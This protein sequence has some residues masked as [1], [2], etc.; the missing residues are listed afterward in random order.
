MPHRKPAAKK[1]KM[2][3]FLFVLIALVS[4]VFILGAGT[5]TTAAQFENHDA[6]CASCHSEPESTYYQRSL[7]DPPVDLASWHTT[8]DVRCIDC[9]AGQGI[10]GR[11]SAMRL[12]AGDLYAYVTHTDTQPAP[13]TQPIGDDHCL[14]CHQDTPNTQDFNRHF[15]AFLPQWQSLDSN[16]AT[17]VDCHA[18][19]NTSGDPT[20]MFLEQAQ[21][22]QVCQS[23]HAFARRG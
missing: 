17:C 16:A 8:K 9:H 4:L 19:H 22:T 21:T 11:L 23:C 13:L 12:G 15:H 7:G 1:Q 10:P 5:A 2:P 6:F 18:S 3:R 20:A 14:K